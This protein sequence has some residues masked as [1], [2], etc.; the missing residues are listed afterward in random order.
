MGNFAENLNL[1]KR[2][3]PPWIRVPTCK[4]SRKLGWRSFICTR[5]ILAAIEQSQKQCQILEQAMCAIAVTA[6]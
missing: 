3:L 2:V 1:G 4:R 5:N 6:L